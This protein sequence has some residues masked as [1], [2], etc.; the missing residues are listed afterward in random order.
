M[1]IINASELYNEYLEIYFDQYMTLLDARE[2]IGIK[3][4][5]INLFFET[6]L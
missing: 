2:K 6:Q 1:Y 4:N 5:P 3:Y